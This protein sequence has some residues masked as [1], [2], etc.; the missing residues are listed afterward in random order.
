MTCLL[1][2]FKAC[3]DA[4]LFIAG[5]ALVVSMSTPQLLRTQSELNMG[6]RFDA[7]FD[8]GAMQF[9]YRIVTKNEDKKWETTAC[10]LIG[11]RNSCNAT[12]NV[13]VTDDEAG[14]LPI[15]SLYGDPDKC[16]EHKTLVALGWG[17]C[18]VAAIGILVGIL[19]SSN[20]CCTCSVKQQS[21]WGFIF[22][23]LAGA[24]AAGAAVLTVDLCG[25]AHEGEGRRVPFFVL[26]QGKPEF[27][28]SFWFLSSGVVL[29]AL[30]AVAHLCACLCSGGSSFRG[31]RGNS[32]HLLQQ[33]V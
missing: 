26:N 2:S 28:Y 13:R 4:L 20:C 1:R 29:Y 6:Y 25:W 15:K 24:L 18:A 14:D 7:Q 5:I 19:A 10:S 27:G 12:V 22:S 11:L 17:A 32:G 21:L 33:P 30:S 9:C 31:A 23:L 3:A 16:D 8:I